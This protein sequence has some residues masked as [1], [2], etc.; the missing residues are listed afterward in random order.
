MACPKC[1]FNGTN[2][3][4]C[5]NCG[6]N[7]SNND[8]TEPVIHNNIETNN[9][10]NEDKIAKDLVS[11]FSVLIVLNTVYLIYLLF[12]QGFYIQYVPTMI[13]IAIMIIGYRGAAQKKPSAG[14]CGIIVS[15]LL[16]IGI[17]SGN[18]YAYKS[19]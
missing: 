13:A 14:I 10:K 5:P 18:I 17:F 12:S 15:I 8:Q 9:S 11:D 7:L 6:T 16:I 4:F 3:K 19:N 1:G 2:E